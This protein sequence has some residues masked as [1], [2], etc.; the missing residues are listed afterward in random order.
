MADTRSP[1]IE[2]RTLEAIQNVKELKDNISA[3]KQKIDSVD[4]ATEEYSNLTKELSRNQA[5]LRNVMNGTNS[6]F[7]KSIQEAQGLDSSY[8]SLVQQLKEA[9]QEWRT[10]PRYLDEVDEAQGKVNQEWTDAAERVKSLRD[11]LK[12]MD[13][14]TGNFTR[15]VGNYSSALQ[16][17]KQVGNDVTNGLSSMSTVLGLVGVNTGTLD[18]LM[19][20]LRTTIGLVSGA[21]GLL[22]LI[23]GFK[24]TTK[25]EKADTV[26]TKANTAS[27]VGNST[28][29][30]AGTAAHAASTVA[31]TAETTATWSLK[32][33]VDALKAALS[34][35]LSVVIS[36]ITTALS[37]LVSWLFSA[38][39]AT[40]D[41]A[42]EAESAADRAEKA[43]DKIDDKL[44]KSSKKRK[45]EIRIMEAEGQSEEKIHKAQQQMHKDDIADREA[46]IA[47]NEKFI[48]DVEE[49]NKD[50][51]KASK[52]QKKF[53]KERKEEQDEYAKAAASAITEYRKEISAITETKN[54]ERLL[55]EAR[56][57]NPNNKKGNNANAEAARREAEKALQDIQSVLDSAL[58]GVDKI[59]AKYDAAFKKLAENVKKARVSEEVANKARAIL[60]KQ[61]TK[62]LR[63]EYAKQYNDRYKA[64]KDTVAVLRKEKDETENVYKGLI[65]NLK[66]SYEERVKLYDRQSA[67]TKR[68]LEED[69]AAAKRILGDNLD[70]SQW[71]TYLNFMTKT[72]AELKGLYLVMLN[73]EKAFADAWGEQFVA[74]LK[75][76][77]PAI[78]DSESQTKKDLTQYVNDLMQAYQKAVQENDVQTA[79]ILR[80][81]LIGNPPVAE[82]EELLAAAQDFVKRMDLKIAESLINSENPLAMYFKGTNWEEQMGIYLEKYNKILDDENATFKEKYDARIKILEAFAKKYQSFMNSYGKATSNVLENVGD[83][84]EAVLQRRVKLGKMEE[85]EAKK[86]FENVKNLQVAA[87]VINTAGAVVQALADT[88]VPSY[89]V[90]VA[91][92]AAALAAGTAQVIKIKNTEFGGSGDAASSTPKMVD[93]TPQLQYTIGLNTADYAEAQAQTPIRA[94]VVDRDLADGLDEYNKQKNETTF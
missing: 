1:V 47:L 94:Y 43:F 77:G 8:N 71:G 39:E 51:E 28:A 89:Y 52:K 3:L 27:R 25:A 75:N 5:A 93:R 13:A 87:A 76:I 35:G 41:L 92:A 49:W 6:T 56:Q 74:A 60:E 81:K 59:N 42:D 14:E 84:W 40:D 15:N 16:G 34:G 88:T 18:N 66:N 22:G 50:Y 68:R 91:N 62:E 45:L 83:A 64:Y 54:E 61:K 78:I 32:K 86:S 69:V 85:E 65:P 37:G 44:N 48:R 19:K 38:K 63:E 67:E 53:W 17:M 55:Y 10:I 23:T 30:A 31:K 79:A 9:T 70:G 90:K 46:Q 7:D 26:A 29:T 33:A 24:N 36:V 58:E 21:K 80:D 11:E 73:D 20:G 72:N 57:R 12:S 82:D 4:T 2:I